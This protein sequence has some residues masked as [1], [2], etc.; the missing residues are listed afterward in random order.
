MHTTF[1]DGKIP[2]PKLIDLCGQSGLDAI[3]ITDHLCT[4]THLLGKSARFL[5][6][7]LT[8]TNWKTYIKELEKERNRAW[9]EYKMLVYTGVEYTH[10]T[11]NHRRNAHVIA[12]D[13]QEF[14]PPTLIEEEWLKAAKQLGALTIAA[15]PLKLRDASSQTYYLLENSDRFA[16]LIDVWE[17]AN[18]RTLWWQMLKRPFSLIASSDLHSSSRWPSWRTQINCEKDPGAIK[19]FLRNPKTERDFIFMT[20]SIS[21]IKHRVSLRTGEIPRFMKKGVQND[22]VTPRSLDHPG[23]LP[24]YV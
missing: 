14:L 6:I 20:G 12:V 9:R 16:P 23:W 15:H 24:S 10:N 11:F 22:F 13:V 21:E 18:A 5:N 2:L 7:T 17:A 1:S 3:A 8:E 19:A 4:A